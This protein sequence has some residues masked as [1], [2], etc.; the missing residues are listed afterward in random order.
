[1]KV[2]EP[3]TKATVR[4][5][6]FEQDEHASPTIDPEGANPVPQV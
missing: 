1:M 6:A 4:Q 3:D 2:H 5:L